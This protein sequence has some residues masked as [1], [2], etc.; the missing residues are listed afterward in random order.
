[1][2]VLMA[3]SCTCGHA[4]I[5]PTLCVLQLDLHKS[6]PKGALSVLQQQVQVEAT[7]AVAFQRRQPLL[8]LQAAAAFKQLEQAAAQVRAAGLHQLTHH[9][10]A[11]HQAGLCCSQRQLAIRVGARRQSHNCMWFLLA[12]V[13]GG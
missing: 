12:V 10:H 2:L 7:V 3:D 13:A 9:P 8:M 1:M 11:P 4:Q 6:A 5:C